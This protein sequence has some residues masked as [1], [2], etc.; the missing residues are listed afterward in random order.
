MSSDENISVTWGSK[1][2]RVGHQTG[3]SRLVV[4]ENGELLSVAQESH[5]NESEKE[6]VTR[7]VISFLLHFPELVPL[8]TFL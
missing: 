5:D 6:G 7:A 2:S 8:I 4:M 3:G 1:W